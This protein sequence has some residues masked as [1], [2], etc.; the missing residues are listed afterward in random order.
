[1]KKVSEVKQCHIIA[2]RYDHGMY[3]CIAF[4]AP[5]SPNYRLLEKA[6]A[7]MAGYD[8]HN[9]RQVRFCELMGA[10]L[11][12]LS[13]GCELFYTVTQSD[14]AADVVRGEVVRL[15]LAQ[16]RVDITEHLFWEYV[17]PVGTSG[18][19]Y[20]FSELLD[21]PVRFSFGTTASDPDYLMYTYNGNLYT[22]TE[23][24]TAIG[25]TQVAG[26]LSEQN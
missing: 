14:K 2:V 9:V 19:L 7:T 3:H 20:T 21:T 18:N 16:L 22:F 8:V 23:F 6:L 12:Q 13:D 17:R 24:K 15:N 26:G 25:L 4:A 1:M 11:H 10:L 5:T